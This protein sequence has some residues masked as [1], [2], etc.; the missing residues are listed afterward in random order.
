[1]RYSTITHYKLKKSDG[2]TF[3]STGVRIL[4]SDGPALAKLLP[5]FRVISPRASGNG[6]HRADALLHPIS[7]KFI[8]SASSCRDF[9]TPHSHGARSANGKSLRC[10]STR[11][12][13]SLVRSLLFP[14]LD[15]PGLRAHTGREKGRE[16]ERE[17]EG[18]D[19]FY[20]IYFTR[21][22]TS[23]RDRPLDFIV[24]YRYDDS[25]GTPVWPRFS[26][27]SDL[28]AIPLTQR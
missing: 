27:I 12:I 4:A 9:N 10:V 7:R 20:I 13:S 16:S 25:R 26:R 3:R 11:A 24:P 18:G 6:I 15:F 14:I 8:V 28:I 22:T 19:T 21:R 5:A 17:R 23:A 1:M 2:G